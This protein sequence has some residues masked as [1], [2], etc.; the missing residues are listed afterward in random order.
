MKYCRLSYKNIDAAVA[1]SGNIYA[2]KNNKVTNK[3]IGCNKKLYN[4]REAREIEHVYGKNYVSKGRY[5]K[6]KMAEYKPVHSWAQG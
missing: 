5:S 4:R 3:V 1:K 6:V 2:I